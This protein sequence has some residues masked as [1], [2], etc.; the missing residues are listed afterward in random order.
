MKSWSSPELPKTGGV[1]G[2]ITW[3]TITLAS[4]SD[5]KK[6]NRWKLFY[7]KQGSQAWQQQLILCDHTCEYRLLLFYSPTHTSLSPQRHLVTKYLLQTHD[8]TLM[9]LNRVSKTEN[10]FRRSNFESFEVVRTTL[11]TVLPKL[12]ENYLQAYFQNGRHVWIC[13]ACRL[14]H[15]M[16]EINTSCVPTATKPDS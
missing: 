12:S 11:T 9:W 1:E 16:E 15:K 5:T 3:S 2:G 13:V 14:L 6:A 10:L 4:I 7:S 8:L